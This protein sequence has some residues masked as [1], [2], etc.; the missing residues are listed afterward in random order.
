MF[1]KELSPF[2]KKTLV[3]SCLVREVLSSRP[4]ESITDHF[5]TSPATRLMGTCQKKERARPSGPLSRLYSA[6]AS[7][8]AVPRLVHS[9]GS[10]W[11]LLMSML[12]IQLGRSREPV[13]SGY[14]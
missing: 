13:R 2:E 7:S 6:N 14:R 9:S 10:A 12:S 11:P 1:L 4:L 3:R 5:Y 8:M